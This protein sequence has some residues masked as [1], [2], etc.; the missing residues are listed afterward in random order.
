MA[1]KQTFCRLDPADSGVRR[2][3]P[4]PL[5]GWADGETNDGRCIADGATAPGAFVVQAYVKDPS[6]T[7]RFSLGILGAQAVDY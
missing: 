3:G 2:S 4:I 5:E 6:A 1:E 7:H